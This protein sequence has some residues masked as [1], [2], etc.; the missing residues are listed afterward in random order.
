[1]PRKCAVCQHPNRRAIETQLLANQ[2]YPKIAN[3][4]GLNWQAIRNHAVNHVRPMLDKA[5]RKAENIVVD[6]L[7]K[8]REE[9]NY[10]PLVKAKWMQDMIANELDGITPGEQNVNSRVALMRE[11]RGWFDIENKITG[12]Y[13]REEY[14]L[15]LRAVARIENIVNQQIARDA[16]FIPDL[17][18]LAAIAAA[19]FGV[20]SE[21][22]EKEFLK[23]QPQ[24]LEGTQ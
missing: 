9:V 16:S 23:R 7:S 17:K 15:V 10:A 8:Y 21:I 4:C 24:L 5:N 20:K 18:R 1:M 12:N 14:E 6:A 19:D 11:L 13:Q 22:V 2:S 3:F